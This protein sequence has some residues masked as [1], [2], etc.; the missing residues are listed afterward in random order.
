MIP[1]T[2]WGRLTLYPVSQSWRGLE[3]CQIHLPGGLSLHRV[4]LFVQVV[5]SDDEEEFAN[6]ALS[7]F[8][9]S[10]DSNGALS[11]ATNPGSLSMEETMDED[12][13]PEH[14]NKELQLSSEVS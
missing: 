14:C 5:L 6:N 11:S 9:Y 12:R 8:G 10:E 3:Q 1:F 4:L 13:V 7:W 2:S